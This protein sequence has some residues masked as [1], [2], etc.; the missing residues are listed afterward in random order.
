ALQ[1]DPGFH[2]AR[3]EQIAL[4]QV[5]L[6]N[7]WVV[8][9]EIT[10]SKLVNKMLQT[11]YIGA[12]ISEGIESA[13][14]SAHI[15]W[16]YYLKY[17]EANANKEQVE[18]HFKRAIQ[19]DCNN[20]YA[21][22]MFGFWKGYNGKQIEDVKK[23][24]KIALLNKETKNY[25]RTLQLSTFL[26]KK[27]DGYEKELFKIVNEMCEHQEKILPR[28]QYEILNIYERNVYD[29][30]RIMEIINYLTPKAHF[31]CL[32]CL[33]NDKQQQKH[34]KQKHQLIKGILFEKMGELE[35]ALNFYQSLQKEIYPH[36]G[37]LSKTIIK[38]IE[39]IHDKQRNK[40]PGL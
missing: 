39:R 15:G 38:A 22:A 9:G 20:G 14:I 32:T 27:T 37:R 30:E 4:A 13:N 18:S 34:K 36:T 29:N 40:L 5:W 28:Y 16:A 19:T 8:K 1:L 17:R 12:A 2:D 24:F 3:K 31:S 10:F 7:I 35:K 25:T 6:R 26:S 21:H 11:L 33:T 23:H